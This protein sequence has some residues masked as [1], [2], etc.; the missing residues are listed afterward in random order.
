MTSE[1]STENRTLKSTYISQFK[2]IYLRQL[3]KAGFNNSK[4]INEIINVD[5]SGFTEAILDEVDYVLIDSLVQ[6]DN[7]KLIADSV[8]R[9]HRVAEG[10]EGKH[11]FEL[12]LNKFQSK[13]LDSIAQQ[14]YKHSAL[15]KR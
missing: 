4:A 12:L 3:L 8:T 15:R 13:W 5:R 6:I 11:I 9:I 2:L 7:Q 1:R 10:A 14:Q